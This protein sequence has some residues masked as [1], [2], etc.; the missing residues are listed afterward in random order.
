MVCCRKSQNF[1]CEHTE[2]FMTLY[3]PLLI[4]FFQIAL[5]GW[6]EMIGE[7]KEGLLM[8]GAF[9]VF[10]YITVFLFR[11]GAK[12][13]FSEIKEKISKRELLR[14]GF[15]AVVCVAIFADALRVM[16]NLEAI[17]LDQV[18][19]TRGELLE[20]NNYWQPRVL[21]YA[22]VLLT[23][24]TIHRAAMGLKYNLFAVASILVSVMN[25]TLTFGRGYLLLNTFALINLYAGTK[26]KKAAVPLVV[27]GLVIFMGIEFARHGDLGLDALVET[28]S[29]YFL[30]PVVGSTYVFRN[31]ISIAL[32][33][34]S[35]ILS[36]F[37]QGCS[38][39]LSQV[40]ASSDITGFV[41]NVYGVVGEWY[42][43]GGV[44]IIPLIGIVYGIACKKNT[45][46]LPKQ[47]SSSV[48][49]YLFSVFSIYYF[50]S[51]PFLTNGVFAAFLVLVMFIA[52]K[53][54]LARK[55]RRLRLKI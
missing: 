17:R 23:I 32:S 41:S 33:C 20:E 31:N 40:I 36:A 52:V 24:I 18:A 25:S 55:S 15:F 8:N 1:T 11:C 43:V 26:S 30:A 53:N 19:A 39:N 2:T 16:P 22:S 51:D 54:Q 27:L 45:N 28:L 50:F 35:A 46:K 5:A 38:G 47:W 7:V 14:F 44:L 3:F 9:L 48:A 29:N 42:A 4:F 13:K 6:R 12:E 21:G 37:S 49:Y 10:F 34:Q